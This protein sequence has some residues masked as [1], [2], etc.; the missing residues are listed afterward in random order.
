MIGRH[1]W[2]RLP[3]ADMYSL[4]DK[5]NG[6]LADTWENFRKVMKIQSNVRRLEHQ[7][8][9]SPEI[10]SKILD[11]GAQ[12][13]RRLP[14]DAFEKYFSN[15]EYLGLKKEIEDLKREL[16]DTQATLKALKA[17]KRHALKDVY[18]AV[19]DLIAILP[20]NIKS[21]KEVEELYKAIGDYRITSEPI[22]KGFDADTAMD[23]ER[24]AAGNAFPKYGEL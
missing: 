16:A 22:D 13:N 19:R 6:L 9:I 17:S 21:S 24:E 23:M 1:N 20:F 3:G 2:H 7:G 15:P 14:E 5:I 4:S 10:G 8:D 12:N 18:Y 11:T